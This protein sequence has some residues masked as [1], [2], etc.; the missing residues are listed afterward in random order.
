MTDFRFMSL[1]PQ[2]E[3]ISGSTLKAQRLWELMKQDMSD[4][5]DQTVHPK[6]TLK[7]VAV[8]TRPTEISFSTTIPIS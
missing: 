4:L 6:M 2:D 7:Q 1:Y 8:S 3:K 5:N